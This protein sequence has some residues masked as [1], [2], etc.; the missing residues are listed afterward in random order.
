MVTKLRLRGSCPSPT[1]KHV[2]LLLEIQ[3]WH[4]LTLVTLCKMMMRMKMIIMK[5]TSM[6]MIVIVIMIPMI[7]KKKHD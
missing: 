7:M 6:M 3:Q 2:Y 5:V 4:R 1:P